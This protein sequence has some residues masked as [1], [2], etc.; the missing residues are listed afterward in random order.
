[1]PIHEYK[2]CTV[3]APVSFTQYANLVSL[4][5]QLR[6]R[7]KYA[8]RSVGFY[9]LDTLRHSADESKILHFIDIDEDW[10]ALISDDPSVIYYTHE[11]VRIL[12]D[13]FEWAT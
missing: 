12:L 5:D 4:F 11:E 6:S 7:H 13:S 2:Y 1:M 3:L 8:D 10:P 9:N